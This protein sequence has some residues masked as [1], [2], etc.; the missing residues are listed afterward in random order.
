MTAALGT[1]LIDISVDPSAGR[2]MLVTEAG[3]AWII[4]ACPKEEE[5]GVSKYSDRL[6]SGPQSLFLY[7]KSR[8]IDAHT[9]QNIQ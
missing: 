1:S 4:T 7:P 9:L 6:N 5:D 2:E 8:P 3:Q